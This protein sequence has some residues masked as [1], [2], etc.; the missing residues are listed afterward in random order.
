MTTEEMT[1]ILD[2]LFASGDFII[3]H[4]YLVDGATVFYED[5]H[6][7]FFDTEELTELMDHTETGDFDSPELAMFGI[8]RM[9]LSINYDL[10]RAIVDKH[11]DQILSSIK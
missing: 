2:D 5:G 1:K 4:D 3:V 9:A 8:V 11:T 10:V 6:T 7:E